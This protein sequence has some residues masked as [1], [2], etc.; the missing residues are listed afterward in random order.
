M[1]AASIYF[2]LIEGKKEEGKK[3]KKEEKRVALI[4]HHLAAMV[5]EVESGPWME[6]M[7]LYCQLYS[8]RK[9]VYVSERW[10]VPLIRRGP[11]TVFLDLGS[12]D[13]CI[14]L[15]LVV[16]VH[17]VGKIPSPDLKQPPLTIGR[18]TSA[19]RSLTCTVGLRVFK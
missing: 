5:E 3:R 13:Q 6:E 9:A 19:G 8:K 1:T 15:Y 18:R 11:Q 7:I 17:R 4:N 10:C 14:D 12:M 2:E 16:Q